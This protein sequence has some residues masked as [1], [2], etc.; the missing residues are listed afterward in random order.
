MSMN[1]VSSVVVGLD[2][3]LPPVQAEIIHVVVRISKVLSLFSPLRTVV[4]LLIK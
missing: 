4:G 2:S 3:E 1:E